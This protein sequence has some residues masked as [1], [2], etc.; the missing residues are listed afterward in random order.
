M[1]TSEFLDTV[2]RIHGDAH[3]RGLYF[4]TAQ[5]QRLRERRIRVHDRDV[6]S[7]SSCSYLGLEHHPALVAGVVDAVER[8]GTQF[9]S[10][11][12]YVSAPPYAELEALL[13][14]IFDG[15]VLVT[16][17][18]TLGHQSAI[19]VLLTERDAMVMDHQVHHSIQVAAR[20]AQAGGA[21]TSLVRHGELEKAVDEVRRLSR[22]CDR[23]WFAVD[24]VFSMYGDLA[25][26]PLLREVLS[27]ADNVWLY[28]DD[29]HGMS[30]A[31]R[32]G[33]GSFLSR[34][35]MHDRLVL[36]TSLNKAFSAGG[37][38]IVF[39]DRATRERVLRCGGAHV[40]SGP[41]QPPML[42]AAIASAHLHLSDEIIGYQRALRSRVDQCHALV[43]ELDLPLLDRNESPILFFRTGLPQVAFDLSRR[44]LDDGY[45]VTPSTYPSVPL[46]RSG[47]R[48]SVTAAHS[49]EQ[50]EDAL[51]ALAAHLPAALATEGVSR[52]DLDEGFRGTLPRAAHLRALPRPE[53]PPPADDR[54]PAVALVLERRER[55]DALDPAEWD[56]MLGTAGSCSHAALELAEAVFQPGGAPE[57]DW[58]FTYLVV[59]DPQGRPVA[60]TFFTTMLS[61]DDMLMRDEVSR[62]V[63]A[64]RARDPYFLTSRIL[65]MG[66][67]FSEGNHLFLDRTGP[68]QRALDMLLDAAV[69]LQEEHDAAA[70]LLR[71]LPTGDDAL[72]RIIHARGFVRIPMFDS[73]RLV[74]DWQ[75]EAQ[76]HHR[77]SRRKRQHIQQIAA[78]SVHVRREVYGAGAG[79]VPAEAL[80]D[81]LYQM[82]R[83]VSSRKLR[84]NV[85]PLPRH[86]LRALC[87][88]PAWELVTVHLDPAAGG[89]ADG[90]PVAW[91]AAHHHAG[92]YAP[93]LCGLDYDY[94]FEHGAYRAM[95]YQVVQ[96][97]R[98]LGATE[99]HL[100]MDADLEKE[101]FGSERRG[102]SV[103]LQARDHYN[104]ALL[105]EIVAEVGLE[106]RA[107]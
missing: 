61:K 80:L 34:M 86:L 96:R 23:V 78:Q 100:G 46:R 7:F 25:P 20:L 48:F 44:L 66:S 77:L 99:V 74:L 105:Q 17:T 1:E 43:D 95:I 64:R 54:A 62:A 29:A 49:A 65:T 53:A 40:F 93:F 16:S 28:V 55:I 39:P 72:D 56:R 69:D 50:V 31:G 88:S 91:Y 3:D 19:P 90:R 67:G 103:Y 107:G 76:W 58:R 104:G 15:H 70:L 26:V 106:R 33:R 83:A 63:E 2:D 60:A 84:L 24:G 87:D 52:A 82:Y 22:T 21:R 30:W 79:R 89:P 18:T 57:D 45:Y 38:C 94:V 4:L 81:R 68:W 51:R 42:G 98:Q 32:H 73:H 41:L 12:G 75:D 36:G 92:H 101:R 5:D 6:V 97:A 14:R 10:S 11:R 59:R 27:V 71:D 13:D 8:Y 9:S 85:F 37:G 47:I 35:P 102:N